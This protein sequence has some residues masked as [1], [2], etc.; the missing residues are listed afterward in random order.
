MLTLYNAV[1]LIILALCG[2]SLVY[3]VA[4]LVEGLKAKK[5]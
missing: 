2:S 5:A 3:L 1:G 4:I